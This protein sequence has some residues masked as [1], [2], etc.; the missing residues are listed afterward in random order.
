MKT[1]NKME[2][3]TEVRDGGFIPSFDFNIVTIYQDT[4]TYFFKRDNLSI[5]EVSEELIKIFINN[6][7]INNY[8][9]TY[10]EDCENIHIS[11]NT[12]IDGALNGIEV[13]YNE[14]EDEAISVVVE[15]EDNFLCS[16][17]ILLSEYEKTFIEKMQ[18]YS[19][20][21]N[22]NAL[23]S[24][25]IDFTNLFNLSEQYDTEFNQDYSSL[26]F[27]NFEKCNFRDCYN[28]HFMSYDNKK[29]DI[30]DI[31]FSKNDIINIGENTYIRKVAIVDV[32]GEYTQA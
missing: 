12:S 9:A 10:T 7:D 19:I 6:T 16:D 15:Y 1:F 2:Y 14:L 17:A 30:R 11:L 4:T 24:Y 22:I 29:I 23:E 26:E 8:L 3:L 13:L 25:I 27:D 31:N 5:F 21:T 20:T 32:L 28:I 18:D